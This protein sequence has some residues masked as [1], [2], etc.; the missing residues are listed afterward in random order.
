MTSRTIKLAPGLRL[1]LD[2]AG[3]TIAILA[4]RGAGKTN[5]ATVLVEEL[6]AANVQT[7]I[8]DPVGAWWGIRSSASGEKGAGL[9]VPILGGQHGDVPLEQT[10]GSLIADVVVDSGQSMLLDLSDFPSKAS[11]NRFV[12]DFAEKL[13]R[14]KARASSLMHL[15]LEEADEFAPQRGQADTA[16]MR[17][18]IE[19]I[20][21]R[22]RSR[23]LGVTL[24]TQRSAVLNK[25]VLTQADVLIVMRTTGPHDVKAIREWVAA[26]GDEHGETV[27]QS[28]PSLETGEAWVW[29]P[30]RDLLDRIKVRRRRTFDSSATPKAGQVRVEPTE[31]AEIDLSALGAQIQATVERVQAN[32]PVALTRRLRELERQIASAPAQVET[33]VETVTETVEVPVLSEGDRALLARALD[34]S[35]VAIDDLRRQL[36]RIADVLER[37]RAEQGRTEE[38]ARRHRTEGVA[39]A[40]RPAPPTAVTRPQPD[41]GEV[42]L[43]AG[44]RR[45]L[46]TMA[47][48]HPMR[49]TRS[50]LGTLAKFKVTGG[51]FLT[52]WSQIK[53]EGLAEE[54]GGEIWLTD[55]GLDYV[56][57]IPAAPQTT[58]ELLDMWRGALK[59]GARTMLDE[60]VAAYPE[61]MTK[62]ELAERVEMTASGGT[63]STYLSTLRRNGLIDVQGGTVRA[64]DTLFL[65]G[66]PS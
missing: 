19:Q 31:T 39:S 47:R 23:G 65:A 29:N 24:I 27:I 10:A 49:M 61:E 9:S 51:T 66:V 15:V 53:R 38:I 2:V 8:V 42:H 28:L 17:G 26:K 22:G 7:V 12:T 35:D 62:D 52:Y 6:V 44:A 5:T 14:R 54:Q 57:H 41:T 56:G 4:K 48:H 30:E 13:Y 55:S 59:A 64:S 16:R 58:E 1:P 50:Q 63:F 43:K 32:D 33:V 3:E 37:P 25:D 21:R 20:V 45:I 40:R 60:L 18:A 46:E 34:T 36:A 11:V